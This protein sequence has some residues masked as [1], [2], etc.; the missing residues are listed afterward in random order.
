MRSKYNRFL[1]ST[2]LPVLA[3]SIFTIPSAHAGFEWTPPEKAPVVD[4]AP[5]PMEAMDAVVPDDV[6][7]E[8]LPELA[9]DALD[10]VEM[11][12]PAIEIKVMDDE[13]A[14]ISEPLDAA[15]LSAE[16]ADLSEI[17]SAVEAIEHEDMPE[18]PVMI[19]DTPQLVKQAA[20]EDAI[21]VIEVIDAP[22]DD[23]ELEPVVIHETPIEEIAVQD[24]SDIEIIEEVEAKQAPT[25][26]SINPYPTET[27]TDA[28]SETVVI[29]DDSEKTLT[30][31]TADDVMNESSDA[32][33][34]A[35]VKQAD[36]ITWNERETFDVIEG[37]G[38]D[39][40]LALAL[41]QIVPAKY[42]FKFGDDLNAGARV[43][44]NGGAPWN[45]VLSDA[46]APLNVGYEIKGNRILLETID[47]PA[48]SEEPIATEAQA[49][50]AEEEI[51]EPVLEEVVILEETAEAEA[52]IAPIEEPMDA[53][54][55]TKAEED[56]ID[57][58]TD[59]LLNAEEQGHTQEDAV[60]SPAD[61][62]NQK[63]LEAMNEAPEKTEATIEEAPTSVE[64]A[65]KDSEIEQVEL[66]DTAPIAEKS[67]LDDI[68][69]EPKDDEAML[70][71]MLAPIE[72]LEDDVDSIPAPSDAPLKE[73][74]VERQK[75][76][77]PGQEVG[78]QPNI[79]EFQHT[80][81]SSVQKK[82]EVNGTLQ[83]LEK[84]T[85]L[86]N[87]D[88]APVELSATPQPLIQDSV[89]E[90]SATLIEAEA[91]TAPLGKDGLNDITPAA[92]AQDKGTEDI[93][94]AH[95]ETPTDTS[96]D[97]SFMKQPSNKIRIWEAKR[98]M[99]LER[100]MKKW[101]A[102]ENIQIIWDTSDKYKLSKDIFISGT[103]QNA[104]DVLFSQGF[105]NGP[106]HSLEDAT[107]TLHIV[108]DE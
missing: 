14:I 55:D 16:K 73:V 91:E 68:Y 44:W 26:L 17:E 64:D 25:S 103:F 5:Q 62:L 84:Q 97:H 71:E 107:Y 104:V 30:E 38:K 2:C 49:S 41:R 48:V 33:F 32:D 102:V 98:G 86:D 23:V 37:F 92:N 43:N 36:P 96:A 42:A 100:I 28:L 29:P 83:Q 45:D 80:E 75:I 31:M 12:E 40:P 8:P 13:P 57:S 58:V 65:P 51:S 66:E 54:E 108:G 20:P 82:N 19:N 52:E 95:V 89:S 34:D 76:T 60:L 24:E 99:S 27:D 93:V 9:D 63:S 61:E 6:M 11:E 1:L 7:T 21:E 79:S 87:A 77:D 4:V 18:T 69:G 35:A 39:I 70:E 59:A 94:I 15:P 50:V 47:A 3:A 105:K 106:K 85:A 10:A 74:N 22:E 53:V 72:I 46:L 90:V 67:P 88:A 101:Q 78:V 81:P 56:D